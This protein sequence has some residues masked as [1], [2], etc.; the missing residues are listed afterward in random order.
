M[1]RA[2]KGRVSDGAAVR[3]R[4]G[5]AGEQR[6]GAVG[7]GV[8][9]EI[10]LP[11]ALT[12]CIRRHVAR[13]LDDHDV[14]C[15]APVEER[16]GVT[17]AQVDAAMGDVGIPLC[18]DRP[19]CGVDVETGGGDSR[20]PVHIIVVVVGAAG[21]ARR[22]AEGGARLHLY[23]VELVQHG[24]RA[25]QSLEPGLAQAHGP[26]VDE[27]VVVVDLHLVCVAVDQGHVLGADGEVRR[28]VAQAPH[29]VARIE[30]AEVRHHVDVRPVRPVVTGAEMHIAVVQPVP[31]AD[32]AGIGR[33]LYALQ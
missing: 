3:R 7:V 32:D 11:V 22:A 4:R 29:A 31:R 21:D 9:T 1:T 27:L 12:G 19:R 10:D 33:D 18:V 23:G 15:L 17:R 5:S 2:L 25:L 24:Q 30:A 16:D 14:T 6:A 26:G 13:V 20:V 28:P 8:L